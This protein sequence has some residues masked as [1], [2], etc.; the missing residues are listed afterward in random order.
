MWRSTGHPWLGRRAEEGHRGHPLEREGTMRPPGANGAGPAVM[1]DRRVGGW[2][3]AQQG[4]AYPKEKWGGQ[5]EKEGA[6]GL[7]AAYHS[8]S[9]RTSSG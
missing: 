3:G 2:S 8:P 6:G 7:R 9:C 5:G 4:S 1:R